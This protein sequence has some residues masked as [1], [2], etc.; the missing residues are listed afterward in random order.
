MSAEELRQ[1]FDRFDL[2]GDGRIDRAE[3]RRVIA[4][5][6]GSAP[7]DRALDATLKALD[8]NGD[9]LIDFTEFSRAMSVFRGES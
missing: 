1:M 4:E 8:D 9:G 2:D 7:S 6:R 5:Q 3:L